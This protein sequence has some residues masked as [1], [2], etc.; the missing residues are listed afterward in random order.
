[1]SEERILMDTAFVLAL[2]DRNDQHHS[3]ARDLLP[4]AR[5]AR[6]LWTTE[7]I[8]VEIGNGSSHFPN[9]RHATFTFIKQCYAAANTQ[10]VNVTTELLERA[11]DLYN[12]RPDKTWG[13]TDCISFVVMQDENLT[14]ALTGDRHFRQAGFRGLMSE[15]YS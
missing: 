1:M 8:L 10:V 15:D 9:D 6:E 5:A 13:L 12:S 14:D 2:L 11:L 7:A 4:R 3:K